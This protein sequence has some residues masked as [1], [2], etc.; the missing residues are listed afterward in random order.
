MTKLEFLHTE[1]KHV[2][3]ILKFIPED[4]KKMLLEK[5]KKRNADELLEVLKELY[6]IEREYFQLIREEIEEAEKF[7]QKIQK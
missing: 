1:I 6:T 2:L 4:E 5:F 3:D 7:L